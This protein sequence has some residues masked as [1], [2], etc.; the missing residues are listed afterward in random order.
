[1]ARDPQLTLT[2][3]QWVLGHAHL[4]TTEL[5]VTP[6]QDEVVAG[7]LAHHARQAARRQEPTP[8]PPAA[9]YD[10]QSLSVLFGRT[11]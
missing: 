10:P 5:Y 4:T 3:V 2:D 1:M 8:T 6:T 9:G 11:L 7:V